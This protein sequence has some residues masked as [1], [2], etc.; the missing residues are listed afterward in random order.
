MPTEDEGETAEVAEPTPLPAEDEGEA[1]EAAEP[2]SAPAEDEGEVAV[3]PPATPTAP[4]TPTATPVLIPPDD[5]CVDCHTDQ[6]KLIAN[7][8][9]EEVVESLSEGEG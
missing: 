9:E 3:V 1:A 4:I 2:T 8:K 5:S 7:A 6:E